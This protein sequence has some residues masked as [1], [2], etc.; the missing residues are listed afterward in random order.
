MKSLCE[1][2]QLTILDY[3]LYTKLLVRM[4]SKSQLKLVHKLHD[5]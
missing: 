3:L 4:S 2:V 1:E 5:H